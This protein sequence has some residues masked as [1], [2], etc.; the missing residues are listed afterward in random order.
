MSS[1]KSKSKAE[2]TEVLRV[3]MEAN[4]I[5]EV[6]IK[7]SDREYSDRFKIAGMENTLK[8]KDL[9]KKQYFIMNELLKAA[10]SQQPTKEA[11]DANSANKE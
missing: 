11:P 4:G 8:G 6:R 3:T 5:A 10:K 7:I 2:K 1:A 9:N